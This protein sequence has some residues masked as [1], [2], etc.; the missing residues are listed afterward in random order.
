[1]ESVVA[2]AQFPVLEQGVTAIHVPAIGLV[3]GEHVV[4][5][6]QLAV[7]A[8]RTRHRPA[9]GAVEDHALRLDP[10]AGGPPG[11]PAEGSA[12]PVA[13]AIKTL[14]VLRGSDPEVAF[15][16][17]VPGGELQS[18]PQKSLAAEHP[19]RTPVEM[20]VRLS[21]PPAVVDSQART[22][23]DHGRIGVLPVAGLEGVEHLH[24]G[25]APAAV[26]AVKVIGVIGRRAVAVEIA[27]VDELVND[28]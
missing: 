2:G 5:S 21:A 1:M 27:F 22:C 25:I 12:D 16:R 26:G 28:R 11:T 14:L 23:A 19:L 4:G 17:L 18:L 15:A 20:P 10:F 7:V 8:D 24:A 3:V 6:D 9:V 13:R